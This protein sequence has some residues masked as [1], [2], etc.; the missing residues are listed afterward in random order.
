VHGD[1]VT[2]DDLDERV[3][4]APRRPLDQRAIGLHVPPPEFL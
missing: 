4:T 3:G 1:L 2:V